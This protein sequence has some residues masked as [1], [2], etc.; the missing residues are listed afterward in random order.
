MVFINFSEDFKNKNLL[1]TFMEKEIIIMSLGG[2]LVFPKDLD[3]I[4]VNFLS[5]FKEMIKRQIQNDK[6]FIF[7]VG[8]GNIARKY[9]SAAKK[10][11][12]FNKE[13]L[14]WVGIDATK[15][16]ASF[17]SRIFKEE[18]YKEFVFNPE[19]EI[20]FKENILVAS[21]WEPGCST[22]FDAVLWAE[23]FG[24]K[25]MINLSN[26]DYV[27][28]KDPREHSDAKKL[29]NV[30]W[31][32]FRKIV[33]DE[34]DP[35]KNVPFD[36]IASKKAQELSMQVLILNGK[37]LENLEKAIAGEEFVGTKIN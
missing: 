12:N 2:S 26:I 29:E 23:K 22:D 16:N 31:E 11:S 5:K 7:V 21:G 10:L 1:I 37:N 4:D 17:V 34:W 8:G 15:M 18:S 9:Q 27:Y 33:G 13:N 20:D 6:R 35:G 30:N 36:P 14:D 28:D 19:E 24:A 25:K 32:D 3:D